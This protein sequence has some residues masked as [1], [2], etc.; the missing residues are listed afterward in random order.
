MN[1]IEVSL[2]IFYTSRIILLS[3]I[4]LNELCFF[5]PIFSCKIRKVRRII[6]LIRREGSDISEKN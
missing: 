2:R 4:Q 3:H 5:M 6:S 1:V